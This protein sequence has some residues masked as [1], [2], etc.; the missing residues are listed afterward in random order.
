MLRLSPSRNLTTNGRAIGGSAGAKPRYISA[1]WYS[2][3]DG[4]YGDWL[5]KFEKDHPGYEYLNDQYVPNLSTDRATTF[6]YRGSRC[7]DR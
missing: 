5:S 6:I 1:T 2:K 4:N 3:R 7:A